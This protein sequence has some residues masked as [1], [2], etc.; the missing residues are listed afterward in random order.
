[1]RTLGNNMAW[2]LKTMNDSNYVITRE[3]ERIA[4]NFIR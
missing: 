3:K 4:T 1:M 2:M